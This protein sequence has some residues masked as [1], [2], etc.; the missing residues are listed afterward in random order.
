LETN[1]FAQEGLGG[2][3]GGESSTGLLRFFLSALPNLKAVIDH[4]EVAR[5]HM[6]Q[7]AL[8]AE[9]HRFSMRHFRSESYANIDDVAAKIAKLPP[10]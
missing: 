5:R 7:I 3:P 8:P 1:A 6:D 9:V 2:H 4:G 10:R